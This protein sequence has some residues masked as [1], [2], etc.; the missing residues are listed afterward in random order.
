MVSELQYEANLKFE[1]EGEEKA[2][3]DSIQK[4]GGSGDNED[5]N[6]A[7]ALYDKLQA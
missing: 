5:A 6:S 1:A 3:I 7:I 2:Q 4:N